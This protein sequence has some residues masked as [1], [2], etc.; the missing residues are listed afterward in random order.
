MSTTDFVKVTTIIA[1][2]DLLIQPAQGEEQIANRLHLSPSFC[3]N[4]LFDRI[5]AD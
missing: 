5:L 2:N 1:V 4:E 3:D